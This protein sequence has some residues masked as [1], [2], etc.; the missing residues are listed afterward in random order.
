MYL[1]RTFKKYNNNNNNSVDGGGYIQVEMHAVGREVVV[2]LG[3]ANLL[4]TEGLIINSKWLRYEIL[5]NNLFAR[6]CQVS[7]STVFLPH[8]RI[9][10]KPFTRAQP[11]NS[12]YM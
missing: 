7:T 1:N 2:L 3:I 5:K 12:F 6:N 10:K 9:Q 4:C 8:I 11:R